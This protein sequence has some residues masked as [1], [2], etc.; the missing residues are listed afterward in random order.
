[1]ANTSKTAKAVSG[2]SFG[3]SPVV[4]AALIAGTV[5]MWLEAV[6]RILSTY[7]IL[8]AWYQAYNLRTGDIAAMWISESLISL[9][10]YVV[11][12]YV[13]FRGKE[14]V[15]TLRLW[16]TI[17]LISVIVAPLIGEIGTPIGI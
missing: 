5:Y 17:L 2:G 16:T 12:A 15:G 6:Y 14:R 4:A 13:V 10:V 3:A 9:V 8:P 11:L 7:G 1:M